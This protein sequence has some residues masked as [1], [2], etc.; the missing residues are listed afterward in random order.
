MFR[1]T[2]LVSAFRAIIGLQFDF[3]SH[4]FILAFRAITSSFWRSETPLIF[5][6]HSEPLLIFVSAFRAIYYLHSGFQSHVLPRSA[7][8]ATTCLHSVFRAITCLPFGVQSYYLVSFDVQSHYSV[9]HSMLL[10][11]SFFSFGVQ[12]HC[13]YSFMHFESPHSFPLLTFRFISP[14]S[15][16]LGSRSPTFVFIG[17]AHLILMILA[18]TLT[19]LTQSPCAYRLFIIARPDSCSI[20]HDTVSWVHDTYFDRVV[21]HPAFVIFI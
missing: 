10:S 13:T 21:R 19:Y 15:Y 14:W 9:R 2:V 5:V 7:F 1:V 12:S 20:A 3:Q 8:G 17:I 6:R 16:H 18:F 11:S 4:I